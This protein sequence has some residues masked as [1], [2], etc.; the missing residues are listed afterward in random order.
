MFLSWFRWPTPQK[1]SDPRTWWP[2]P[3][4]HIATNWQ[5]SVLPTRGQMHFPI[6]H[7]TVTILKK[8]KMLGCTRSTGR[9]DFYGHL[10]WMQKWLQIIIRYFPCEEFVCK[11]LINKWMLPM[12]FCYK[13]GCSPLC[14]RS[15]GKDRSISSLQLKSVCSSDHFLAR[16][17]KSTPI[18]WWQ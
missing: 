16:S 12:L 15:G 13:L 11:Y 5:R 6:N 3:H 1:E 10:K 17:E 9:R 8:K 2:L 14:W 4:D 18:T 7:V